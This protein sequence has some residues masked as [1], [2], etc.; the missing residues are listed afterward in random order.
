MIGAPKSSV[1][2]S[3]SPLAAT[4]EEPLWTAKE[5]AAY[6]RCSQ[7]WVYLHAAAG[8]LPHVKVEGL[9]RFVPEDIRSFVRRGRR[10][11]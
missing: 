5:V 9:L 2:V 8:T 10:A 1:A 4:N 7:N 11:A 3:I 6:L